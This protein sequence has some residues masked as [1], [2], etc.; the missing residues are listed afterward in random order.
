MIPRWFCYVN[1]VHVHSFARRNLHRAFSF[2]IMLLCHSTTYFIQNV[3]QQQRRLDRCS[4]SNGSSHAIAAVAREQ[5][6][7]Q[8]SPSDRQRFFPCLADHYVFPP[9]NE[10]T[11]ERRGEV[12]NTEPAHARKKVAHCRPTTRK[13]G[14]V[15]LLVEGR[16]LHARP[17]RSPQLRQ[18]DG[19]SV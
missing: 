14:Q 2:S 5:R 7:I 9:T 18:M 10:R 17:E 15:S 19:C 11:N 4:D 13:E 16:N 6:C 12:I 8:I 3:Q 1:A